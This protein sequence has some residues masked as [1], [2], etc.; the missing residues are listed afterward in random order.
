MWISNAE[1][2]GV[3]L[4]MANVDT[5]YAVAVHERHLRTQQSAHY[6]CARSPLDHLATCLMFSCLLDFNINAVNSAGYKGITCFVV[7]GETPGLEVGRKEDKLGIR[8]S[9]TCPVTFDNVKV[10]S[11]SILGEVGAGY[12]YVRRLN[13]SVTANVLSKSGMFCQCCSLTG[14]LAL[15]MTTA[16]RI[17]I[18]H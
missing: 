15:V 4:V 16:I 1:H 9:S 18:R 14:I 8:A 13:S 2:A 11:D 10:P 7:D 6:F 17:Q 5:R 3:F 12:K